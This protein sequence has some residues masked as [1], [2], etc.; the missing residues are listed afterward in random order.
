VTGEQALE[1]VQK[2]DDRCGGRVERP[3]RLP[4]LSKASTCVKMPAETGHM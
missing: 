1:T 4:G 2:V 3:R